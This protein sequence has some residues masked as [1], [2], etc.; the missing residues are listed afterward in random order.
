ML[1]GEPKRICTRDGHGLGQKLSFC[2]SEIVQSIAKGKAAGTQVLQLNMAEFKDPKSR[3]P[4]IRIS[5]PPLLH[6]VSI[7]AGQK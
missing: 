2:I 5:N 1:M 4:P 3:E 6:S 7:R